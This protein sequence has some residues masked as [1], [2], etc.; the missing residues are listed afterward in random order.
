MTARADYHALAV[1][2]RDSMHTI[3]EL[4]SQKDLRPHLKL[5]LRVLETASSTAKR[6]AVALRN[7][8]NLP[9]RNRKIKLLAT[10]TL[11]I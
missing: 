4:E 10:T 2:V 8:R 9:R 5:L 3:S 7:P 11:R 6:L 1:V